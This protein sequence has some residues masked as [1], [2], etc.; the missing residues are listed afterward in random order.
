MLD[1]ASKMGGRGD[2][3]GKEEKKQDA[4]SILAFECQQWL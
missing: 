1:Q 3:T 4:A 2:G